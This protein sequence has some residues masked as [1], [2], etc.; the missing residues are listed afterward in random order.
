M[1]ASTAAL[2]FGASRTL[3]LAVSIS[4]ASCRRDNADRQRHAS[5]P[6]QLRITYPT[7]SILAGRPVTVLGTTGNALTSVSLDGHA[8]TVATNGAFAAVSPQLPP[9]TRAHRL[10][11]R[12][13]NDSIVM[14]VPIVTAI[15]RDES[16]HVQPAAG[17]A[18]GAAE[19]VA[20]MVVNVRDGDEWNV[21]LYLFPGTHVSA[22]SIRADSVRLT[23][24]GVAPMWVSAQKARAVSP[25]TRSS[26]VR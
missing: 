6:L 25:S 4:A 23:P 18:S 14:S 17:I 7:T 12:L 15:E 16:A 11:A 8:G 2:S 26:A 1:S 5:G 24:S 10:V 21:W 20:P 3:L 9:G 13:G 19:V 22:D